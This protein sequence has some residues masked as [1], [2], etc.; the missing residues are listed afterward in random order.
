MAGTVISKKRK[1][2]FTNG[3]FES[4]AKILI[5]TPIIQ[6]SNALFPGGA[7]FENGGKESL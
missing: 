2:F 3:E 6:I 7:V 1:L 5:L 4:Q